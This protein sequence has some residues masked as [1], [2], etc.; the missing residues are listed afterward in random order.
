MYQLINC[1]FKEGD[2]K[3]NLGQCLAESQSLVQG[4][5]W[6]ENFTLQPQNEKK[7]KVKAYDLSRSEPL[8][9][10]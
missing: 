3:L 1:L 2:D 10:L 5:I 4:E 6:K 7:F 8:I 9:L